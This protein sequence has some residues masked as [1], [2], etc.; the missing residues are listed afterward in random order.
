MFRAVAALLALC[1]TALP[2]TAQEG[3]PMGGA[4]MVDQSTAFIDAFGVAIDRDHDSTISVEEMDLAS[5]DVFTS[6]DT[7][8]DARLT[9]AEM[10]EW[11]YGFAELAAFRGR[12]AEFEVAVTMVFDLLDSDADGGISVAEHTSGL[13]LARRLADRDGDGG[14]SLTEFREDFIVITAL[15][16]GVGS[17]GP[18]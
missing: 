11:E 17:A 2:A 7:D 12:Q 1:L 8:G 5:V 6:M 15:R 13:Q 16:R 4:A 3:H 14:L 10:M 9:R 18:R